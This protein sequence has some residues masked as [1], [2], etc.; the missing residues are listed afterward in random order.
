VASVEHF[1]NAAIP[2]TNIMKQLIS[3]IIIEASADE[4]W[5][6]LLDHQAYPTWNPFIKQIS[7]ST[8]VGET[9]EVTINKAKSNPISNPCMN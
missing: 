3:D 6:E 2:R 7:G 5:N 8:T 4:V 9:L 1:Y